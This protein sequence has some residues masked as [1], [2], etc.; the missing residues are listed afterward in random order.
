MASSC[1]ID[2]AG[3]YA[4]RRADRVRSE[5]SVDRPAQRSEPPSEIGC[6]RFFSWVSGRVLSDRDPESGGGV[7]RFP[8]R[9]GRNERARQGVSARRGHGR[10][11]VQ[12]GSNG[13]AWWRKHHAGAGAQ[14][15]DRA[16][17][18]AASRRGNGTGLRASRLLLHDPMALTVWPTRRTCS[19]RETICTPRWNG[20]EIGA[21]PVKLRDGLR[22]PHKEGFQ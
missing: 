21:L 13:A 17:R 15:S 18:T 3:R 22:A 19:E 12:T 2:S 16:K 4:R 20:R 9:G 8:L 11:S 5:K 1:G 6:H 14:H 7:R 10:A